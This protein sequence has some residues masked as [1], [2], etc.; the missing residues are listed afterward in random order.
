MDG[1]TAIANILRLEGVD[2]IGCVPY[3]PLLE[4]SAPPQ[5]HR[6]GQ[7]HPVGLQS[8]VGARGQAGGPSQAGHQ[9]HAVDA[10]RPTVLEF[11]TRDEGEYSKFAFV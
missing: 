9:H 10:G 1:V 6:L 2:F 11:I 4:A 3:Q 8:G 5:F 7:I